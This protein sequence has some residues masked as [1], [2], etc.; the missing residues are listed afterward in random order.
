MTLGNTSFCYLPLPNGGSVPVP[1]RGD[2]FAYPPPP[3]S[4][5][6]VN[7]IALSNQ[8]LSPRSTFVNPLTNKVFQQEAHRGSASAGVGIPGDMGFGLARCGVQGDNPIVPGRLSSPDPCLLCLWGWIGRGPGVKLFL[9]VRL[10]NAQQV[11]E[12]TS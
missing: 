1:C 4:D 8:G 3:Y 6:F 10:L 9:P 2:R 11:K 7:T 12:I 5:N